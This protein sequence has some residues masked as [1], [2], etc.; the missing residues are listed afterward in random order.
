M[1]NNAILIAL[2]CGVVALLYGGFT[3]SWI[4]R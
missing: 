2:V 1:L 3:A 4:L